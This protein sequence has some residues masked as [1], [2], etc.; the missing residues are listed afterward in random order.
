M[1]TLRAYRET[2]WDAFLALDL[3]TGDVTLRH[4]TPEA[5]ARFRQRWPT[6]LRERYGW[7]A[8]GP[9]LDKAALYV[10]EDDDGQYAGH[11]WLAEQDDVRTGIARLWVTTMAIVEKHRSRGWGRLLVAKAEE[12]ARARG[13][14]GIGLGVDADNVVARKLYEEM[15]FETVRLRMVRTL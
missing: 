14:G 9:T 3:E 10:L 5:R 2:D 4:D 7:T 8:S 12:V 13:L 15:G 6:V 1:P 11:L